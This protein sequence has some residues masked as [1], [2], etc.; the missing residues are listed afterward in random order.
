MENLTESLRLSKRNNRLFAPRTLDCTVTGHAPAVLC[1]LPVRISDNL[2]GALTM[3]LLSQGRLALLCCLLGLILLALGQLP[4]LPSAAGIGVSSVGALALLL[5]LW[6]LRD[7]R[8]RFQAM[9]D[10]F[11]ARQTKS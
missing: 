10:D 9:L 11:Q 6:A 2:R 5:A 3:K 4:A 8:G 7:V 1:Y